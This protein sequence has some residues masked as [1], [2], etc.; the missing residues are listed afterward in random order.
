M[1]DET[2]KLGFDASEALASLKKLQKDFEQYD[3]Q[4]RDAAKAS[5]VFNKEQGQVQEALKRISTFAELATGSLKALTGAQVA[6]ARAAKQLDKATSKRG[7][8]SAEQLANAAAARKELESTLFKGFRGKASLPEIV[9]F[10]KSLDQFQRTVLNTDTSVERVKGILGDLRGAYSGTAR[11]VRDSVAQVL[12]ATNSLGGTNVKAT[13]KTLA[14]AG[15][16]KDTSTLTSDDKFGA[17]LAAIRGAGQK[18]QLKQVETDLRNAARGA[19]EATDETK[20]FDLSLQA[21]GKIAVTQVALSGLFRLIGAF[22]EATSAAVDFEIS[23]AEI[24]TISE[25]FQSAGL[26]GTSEAIT[27]LSKQFGVPIE[28]VAAGLY[29]TLSNQIGTAA[30]STRFMADAMTFGRAAVTSTAGSVDVLSSVIN[31]YGLSASNAADISGKLFRVIDLGRV[32]GDELSESFGRVLPLAAEL[33]VSFDEIAAGVAHLTIQ[34][35]KANEAYTLLSNVMLK[36]IRPTENLKKEFNDLGISSAEF[37]VQAFGLQGLLKRVTAESGNSASEVGELFNQIRG[38]RGVLGIAGKSAEEYAKTLKQIKEAGAE[39]SEGA[40]AIIGSTNAKQFQVQVAEL[41]AVLV[42]D[43]GRTAVAGITKL[44]DVLGGGANVAKIF[45]GALGLL[46]TGGI[47]AA[48]AA[49]TRGVKALLSAF[50]TDKLVAFG[51][52]LKAAVPFLGVATAGAAIAIAISK[53]GNS[54]E[55]ATEKLKRLREEQE[56]QRGIDRVSQRGTIK[57]RAAIIDKA[58]PQIAESLI[59]LQHLFNSDATKSEALQEELNDSL[60]SQLSKRVSLL[61]SFVGNLQG[62][63]SRAANKIQ[64]IT[65]DSLSLKFQTQQGQFGRGIQGLDTPAQAQALVSRSLQI[66]AAARTAANNGNEEFA[67]TLFAE[68]ASTADQAANLRQGQVNAEGAVNKVLQE[69]LRFNDDLIRQQQDASTEAAK[70]EQHNQT[71]TNEV[72]K[73]VDELN[74]LKLVQKGSD[75]DAQKAGQR[76]LQIAGEIDSLL[77]QVKGGRLSE[78]I[79]TATFKTQLREITSPSTNPL[80]GELTTFKKSFND[81]GVAVLTQFRE[82]ASKIPLEFK[83]RFKLL[84]GEDF[85]FR[86]AQA[87]FAKAVGEARTRNDASLGKSDLQNDLQLQ[88]KE[89]ETAVNNIQNNIRKNATNRIDTNLTKGGFAAF[90]RDPKEEVKTA[91][92]AQNTVNRITQTAIQGINEQD[93]VKIVA[94]LKE[95][96]ALRASFQDQSGGITGFLGIGQAGF[97]QSL[98]KDLGTV[99]TAINNLAETFPKLQQAV[100]QDNSVSLFADQIQKLPD[101]SQQAVT[102]VQGSFNAFSTEQQRQEID[103]LISKINSIPALPAQAVQRA[104]GGPIGVDTATANFAPGEFIVNQRAS[105]M[106]RSQLVAMNRGIPNFAAGG[107]VTNNNF[108][109]VSIAKVTIGSEEAKRVDGGTIDRALRRAIRKKTIRG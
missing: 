68:A 14:L 60:K 51:S 26:E 97:A 15:K 71:I 10:D 34:G 53:I 17:Q 45:V 65:N 95:I 24:Q 99:E 107:E 56:A 63:Q 27:N 36:L 12:K 80:T 48:T 106:F 76:Q 13:A 74:K 1:A 100:L 52:A 75:A 21:I 38:T 94:A 72:V 86:N 77:G 78:V 104:G 66:L 6:A 85:D 89:L 49:I 55:D 105:R 79:D 87:V 32:R 28:D 31:S 101:V 92:D 54:A 82:S 47:V 84:T 22:K 96:K 7:G 83:I 61:N 69:R 40:A 18:A 41:R 39:A 5:G 35:I 8:P 3:K 73:R 59:E 42:N 88:A 43:V 50:Q 37:G 25:T 109:G 33:G 9:A 58:V 16:Q 81:T 19:K 4:V 30:E 70:L 93:P 108:G 11:A 98:D 67:K 23:L 2:S 103:A 62:I 57:E 90:F 64:D 46:A 91:L 102:R 20:K 44:I 29:E